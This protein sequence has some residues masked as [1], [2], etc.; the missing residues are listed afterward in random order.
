MGASVSSDESLIC[1][2][3]LPNPLIT[4]TNARS[5]PSGR[6]NKEDDKSNVTSSP[7][8]KNRNNRNNTA[9]KVIDE[10]KK[11]VPDP[12]I[13]HVLDVSSVTKSEKGMT[14]PQLR[15]QVNDL[16]ITISELTKANTGFTNI[17]RERY[18]IIL[19]VSF[20]YFPYIFSNLLFF[21]VMCS[22]PHIFKTHSVKRIT[23]FEIHRG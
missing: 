2:G 15:K 22:K 16:E 4:H 8:S 10:V 12:P 11:I 23:S 17:H 7:T 9:D 3:I 13:P 18:I 5:S 19:S 20:Y 1:W 21:L 6:R 14:T